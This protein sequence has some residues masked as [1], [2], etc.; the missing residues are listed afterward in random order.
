MPIDVHSSQSEPETAFGL[1]DYADYVVQRHGSVNA[2][3]ASARALRPTSSVSMRHT[4]VFWVTEGGVQRRCSCRPAGV[5]GVPPSVLTAVLLR[6]FAA[7]VACCYDHAASLSKQK[8]LARPEYMIYTALS[9]ESSTE[10]RDTVHA[11]RVIKNS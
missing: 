4:G 8:F 11:N 7:G 10:R 1:R 3:N 9:P 5:A 6:H 2:R